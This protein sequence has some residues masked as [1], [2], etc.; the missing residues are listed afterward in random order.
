MYWHFDAIK[1]E[2]KKYLEE[3]FPKGIH[4]VVIDK[5]IVDFYD[6]DLDD[7]WTLG[8]SE[9]STFIHSDP[10]GGPVAPVQE[11]TNQVANMTAQTVDYGV[12]AIFADVRILNRD[13]FGDQESSPG[14]ITP[15]RKPAEFNNIGDGFYAQP[16]AALSKEVEVFRQRLDDDAQFVLGDY[17]T[18][19]GEL[20]ESDRRTL[21]EYMQ[22]QQQAFQRLSMTYEYLTDWWVGVV[23]KGVNAMASDIKKFGDSEG[24]VIKEQGQF[25][26]IKVSP[27]DL[28]GS[29]KN[30]EPEASSHFP[31][32]SGQKLSL[33]VKLIQMNNP[34]VN[35]VV[36]H[37][38]NSHI[39]CEALGFPELYI[40]GE[41]QRYKALVAIR[42]L[43]KLAPQEMPGGQVMPNT[44]ENLPL[45]PDST[46][47]E[48]E[49]QIAVFKYF[50]SSEKGM[51]IR[52]K[53]P[54]GYANCQSY[55]NI[56]QQS[57]EKKHE[58]QMEAQTRQVILA[59]ELRK[60][61]PPKPSRA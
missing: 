8:K 9:P 28:M 61:E 16:M 18:I 15:V 12:P 37:P 60:L 29:A 6:E 55:M 44:P 19:S 25:E 40:P 4:F 52:Q 32:T 30:L 31:L 10:I 59:K 24:I 21:G 22:S 33:L 48:E 49:V 34:L 50:L 43:L 13:L 56:M 11:L 42:E 53:N 51:Q 3:K 45:K 38:E 39:I 14:M 17:P 20:S 7:C 26:N 5:L 54:A 41:A 23:D 27:E 58:M 46:I 35:A 1:K 2:A 57:Y 47:D 36:G